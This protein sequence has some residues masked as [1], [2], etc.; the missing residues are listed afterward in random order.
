M[1]KKKQQFLPQSTFGLFVNDSNLYFN[2]NYKNV[3]N[4]NFLNF[5]I[6]YFVKLNMEFWEN[7]CNKQIAN[8]ARRFVLSANCMHNS[9]HQRVLCSHQSSSNFW[10]KPNSI[11][12]ENQSID[13][14]V[15]YI[16]KCENLPV[17]ELIQDIR[18]L[19]LP[20][21]DS[22]NELRSPTIPWFSD[23]QSTVMINRW[24][25]NIQWISFN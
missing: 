20:A 11:S 15:C 19:I 18:P 22:L 12:Y 7:L 14:L 5:S 23:A 4:R 6:T 25:F 3:Q 8:V 24:T 13:R 10:N 9:Y 17:V 2:A 16:Y 21:L 1:K